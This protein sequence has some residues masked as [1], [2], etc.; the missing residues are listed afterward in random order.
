MKPNTVMLAV[1]AAS[2]LTATPTL[3]QEV[4]YW[5][6]SRS[7]ER[8]LVRLRDGYH[9]VGK[10][11]EIPGLGKVEEV[12]AEMLVV[13]RTLTAAE[14]QSLAA[15]GR[16]VPDVET[17]RLPNLANRVTP[18]LSGGTPTAPR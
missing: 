7:T 16:V 3:A 14:R 2:L 15:Q 4:Q 9:T 11:D 6:L 13:R 18:P 5:G 8:G 12:T 10:G 1:L 17:R